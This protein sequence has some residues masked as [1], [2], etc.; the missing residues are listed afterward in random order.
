MAFCTECGRDMQEARFCPGCGAPAAQQAGVQ[1]VAAMPPPTGAPPMPPSMT[2][3]PPLIAPP[4]ARPVST[5]GAKAKLSSTG[6]A[7]FGAIGAFAMVL[8][9]IG[10]ALPWAKVSSPLFS[11]TKGGLSGDGVITLIV[12]FL[13]LAFFAVGAA[14]KARWP[15][16][17]GLVLSI[18]ISAVALIDTVDVAGDFTVGIGLILCLAAGAVGVI[19][20]IGG[21]ASPRSAE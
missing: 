15:F 14:G 9:A 5:P 16:I 6:A 3:P 10:S 19:A 20:G 4:P 8:V 1:P 11:A 7:A 21:I 13:A 18:I 12:G 2:P 17:V